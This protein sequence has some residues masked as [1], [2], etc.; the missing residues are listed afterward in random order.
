MKKVLGDLIRKILSPKK[1][2]IMRLGPT[3][4]PNYYKSI[5]SEIEDFIDIKQKY[6]NRK[7]EEA[8]LLL[9]R[10]QAH[11][12]DKGLQRNDFTIG[13][14]KKVYTCAIEEIKKLSSEKFLSDPSVIWSKEKIN[15][16]E[17]KQENP[18]FDFNYILDNNLKLP[19]QNSFKNL[20][21]TRRSI[22]YF[23]EKLVSEQILQECIETINWAPSSCN[24]QPIKVYLTN[25][26][27]KAVDCA[28]NCKGFTGFSKFIPCFM[29][30]CVDIRGYM[31]PSEMY[32]PSVDAS[33]GTQNML[34]MMHLKGLSSSVLS[35]AQK[36]LEEEE[37]LRKLLDIPDYCVIIFNIVVGYADVIPPVPV[38]KSIDNTMYL[39][40]DK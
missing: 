14:S 2:R 31:Y 6:Y 27:N 15:E 30:I 5:I 19:D 12:L 7:D 38:R 1:Y 22:R 11:M 26:P 3:I 29:A 21:Y 9:L 8:A 18:N 28:K 13:H 39:K 20:I 34:L 10:K 25:S 37:N 32:L 35:W 33:L 24:K 23:K 17:T 4:V 40:K 16:Y 36:D